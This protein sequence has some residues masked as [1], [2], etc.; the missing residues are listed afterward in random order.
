[1]E[2]LSLLLAAFHL[3]NLKSTFQATTL[4]ALEIGFAILMRAQM[5]QHINVATASGILRAVLANAHSSTIVIVDI[6]RLLNT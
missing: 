1:M 5:S 6:Q 2:K 4:P 3:I